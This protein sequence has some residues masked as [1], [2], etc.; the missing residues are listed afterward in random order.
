MCCLARSEWSF[1]PAVKNGNDLTGRVDG[2]LLSV[3]TAVNYSAAWHDVPDARDLCLRAT[4]GRMGISVRFTDPG[5]RDLHRRNHPVSVC[6]AFKRVSALQSDGVGQHFQP[7]DAQYHAGYCAD[8]STD[9]SA[10]YRVE[11]LQNAGTNQCRNDPPPQS[12]TLLGR[13]VRCGICFGLSA[14]C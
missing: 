14:F 5:L 3:T 8:F 11:L 10:L 4:S 13:T 1:Q 7:D 6:D 2:A 9:R 12:R